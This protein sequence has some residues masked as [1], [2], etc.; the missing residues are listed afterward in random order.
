LTKEGGGWGKRRSDF[1]EL[2][3]GGVE[4]L[5]TKTF[6]AVEDSAAGLGEAE[7]DRREDEEEQD[8]GGDH[9]DDDRVRPVGTSEKVRAV[10]TAR[11]GSD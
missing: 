9:S 7:D 1:G 11:V 6:L 4:T 5:D 2:R 3:A 10:V 8:E